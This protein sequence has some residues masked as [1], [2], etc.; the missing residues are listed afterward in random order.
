[1]IVGA[2]ASTG[3]VKGRPGLTPATPQLSTR[4]PWGQ[5]AVATGELHSPLLGPLVASSEALGLPTEMGGCPLYD[6]VPLK[7]RGGGNR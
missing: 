2:A 7:T 6:K 5:T 3:S 4:R 1:M